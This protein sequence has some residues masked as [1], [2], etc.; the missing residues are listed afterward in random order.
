MWNRILV[1]DGAM[2][3]MLQ[4]LGVGTVSTGNEVVDA[5][6]KVHG[7]YIEAGADIISTHTFTANE[8]DDIVERN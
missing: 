5:V 8:G 6:Y 4:K 3:T 7:M 2:G 1:L